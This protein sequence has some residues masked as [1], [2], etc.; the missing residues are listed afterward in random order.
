MD[1]VGS[2][3]AS[4]PP[5]AVPPQN[6]VSSLVHT[7][8]LEDVVAAA[9][10]HPDEARAL[11]DGLVSANRYSDARSLA[12]AAPGANT[13]GGFVHRSVS[14]MGAAVQHPD[15]GVVG[16][17]KG[18]LNTLS[19]LG[20][21]MLRGYAMQ[22]AGMQYQAAGQQ[23]LFGQTEA[24]KRSQATGDKILQG[25]PQ[26]RLP[27]VPFNTP[28]EAGGDKIATTAMAVADGVG[29]VKGAV[30]GLARA[31]AKT[32]VEDGG[33]LARAAP[34]AVAAPVAGAMTAARAGELLSTAHTGADIEAARTALKAL[35][36]AERKTALTNFAKSMDVATK[37]NTA[38]FYSGGQTVRDG[39][40]AGGQGWMSARSVAETFAHSSGRTTLESTAGGRVLDKLDVYRKGDALLDADDANDVWRTASSRYAQGATGEVTAFT[41]NMRP[42]SI[43]TTTER[44]AL[45]ASQAAGRVTNIV[46][47]DI[48]SMFERLGR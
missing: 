15:Q 27:T 45:Q 22:G 33:A 17:G 24:A 12:E 21:A 8:K 7:G 38:V 25:A 2:V 47:R 10:A 16:A 48:P 14:E 36:Y 46:E 6:D 4:P 32:A 35:P 23:A 40:A 18:I 28:A 3:S 20:T 26:I 43:Y 39:A 9:K 30:G 19:D 29:L 5:Q 42:N 11:Y 34:K 41:G 1:P 37:P 31:G 44:P 13:S